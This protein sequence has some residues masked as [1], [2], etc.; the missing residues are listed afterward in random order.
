MHRFR[1]VG[2]LQLTQNVRDM[3]AHRF[4][5]QDEVGSDVGIGLALSDQ[6]ENLVFALGQLRKELRWATLGNEVSA[7]S[8]RGSCQTEHPGEVL[9]LPTAPTQSQAPAASSVEKHVAASLLIVG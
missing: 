5:A 2:D 7:A 4:R 9:P 6:R 3:V 1:P 8:C